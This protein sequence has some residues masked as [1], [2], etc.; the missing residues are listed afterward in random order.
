MDVDAVSLLLGLLTLAAWA[1]LLL[2]LALV[3]GAR[4]GST[5]A[6]GALE[7]LRAA[8]AAQG[9]ALALVV[10]GVATSGS[11]YLSE[12]ANFPPCDLCWY[13]RIAMYP[14]V[15]LLG[16]AVL[17]RDRGIRPYALLLTGLGGAVST[18]HVALERIPALEGSSGCDPSN[19]CTIRW[20]EE[21]GFLTIPL[22]AL[23][24]FALIAAILVLTP[25]SS[26]VHREHPEPVVPEAEEV[27]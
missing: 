23:S 16:L 18:Y 15:P 4:G 8:L 5:A 14:L 17:R 24:A 22:M 27:A 2:T 26:A 13:Q 10:A 6:G 12:V 7:E 21:F 20:I 25:A 3:L 9:L 1:G 11:L 19:P